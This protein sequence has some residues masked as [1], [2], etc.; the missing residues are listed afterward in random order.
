MNGR[1]KELENIVSEISETV[2]LLNDIELE[3]VLIHRYLLFHIIEQT[4]ELM[5]YSPVTVK[6]KQKKAIEKLSKL[7]PPTSDNAN[8]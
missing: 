5:H 2:S 4:A 3:T 7:I 6:G 8:L 1:K